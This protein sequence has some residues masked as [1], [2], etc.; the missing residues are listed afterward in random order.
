[1]SSKE[2]KMQPFALAFREKSV[3]KKGFG[4]FFFFLQ[5]QKRDFTS[6]SSRLSRPCLWSR[7]FWFIRNASETNAMISSTFTFKLYAFGWIV[8]NDSIPKKR[9]KKK[10]SM[11]PQNFIMIPILATCCKLYDEIKRRVH[12]RKCS[13]FFILTITVIE[14]I[15]LCCF[16]F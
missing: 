10:K 6:F 14:G 9:K 13:I 3:A 16:H 4:L 8:L 5:C 1:M 2:K 11:V 12:L 7:T 15:T